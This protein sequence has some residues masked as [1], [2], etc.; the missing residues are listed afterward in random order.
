MIQINSHM[1][2]IYIWVWSLCSICPLIVQCLHKQL[3]MLHME[4][5]ARLMCQISRHWQTQLLHQ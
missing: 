3:H 4:K 5:N 2:A 1:S